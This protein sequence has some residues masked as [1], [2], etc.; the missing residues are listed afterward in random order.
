M[1]EIEAPWLLDGPINAEGFEAYVE[2]ALV[3]TL[4]PGDLAI[5][6]NLG[7]HKGKDVRRAIRSSRSAH[8][9]NCRRRDRRTARHL[10]P[11]GMRQ[12]PRKRR[13]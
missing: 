13:I 4:R 3:P 7:S 12:L 2:K 1:I 11:P 6:Y 10:H 5:M 9:R 8:D